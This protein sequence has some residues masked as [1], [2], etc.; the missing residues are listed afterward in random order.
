[1]ISIEC[2]PEAPLVSNFVTFWSLRDVLYLFLSII[3]RIKPGSNIENSPSPEN[4]DDEDS[5][6]SLD[7]DNNSDES[8]SGILSKE[9]VNIKGSHQ[10]EVNKSVEDEKSASDN[11]ASDHEADEKNSDNSST[12]VAVS[13]KQQTRFQRMMARKNTGEALFLFNFD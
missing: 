2:L 13:K 1:M 5:D 10:T 4:D 3:V 12:D 6:A 11:D 8:N 7:D 9:S